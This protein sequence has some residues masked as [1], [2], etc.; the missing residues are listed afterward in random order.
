M[1][2]AAPPDTAVA[3]RAIG[4]ALA[5]MAALERALSRSTRQRPV[6]PE[7]GTGSWVE[8]DQR[9]FQAVQ[10]AVAARET[11][12]GRFDPTILP[13][14]IAAGYDRT[15]SNCNHAM[16]ATWPAGARALRSIS[17]RSAQ[18]SP[19]PRHRDRSR[20]DRKGA[21]GNGSSGHD[22][23]E[24]PALPGALVDLGGDMAVGG[25]A[26]DGAVADR[27]RRSPHARG[28]AGRARDDRRRGGHVWPR[29]PP[30]RRR[31]IPAPPD[32]PH[33]GPPGDSR[34]DQC[35]RDRPDHRRGRGTCNGACDHP[36][37]TLAR[38]LDQRPTLSALVVPP[39]AP[40]THGPL[41]LVER[42]AEVVEAA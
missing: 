35:N 19:C 27:G 33:H 29:P 28:A 23:P 14:L 24:W 37:R 1:V 26:P 38:V 25:L 21:V 40:F 34:A 15:F 2:S 4:A 22:A 42:D 31:S 11:T 17:I 13:A 9:L 5:E 8:V 20:G 10:A 12:G 36:G 32:R 18:D 30:V 7:R 3:R 16:P 39:R 41:P 6:P